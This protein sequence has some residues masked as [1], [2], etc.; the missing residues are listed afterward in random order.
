MRHS[1]DGFT[2]RFND[3]ELEEGPVPDMHEY[4]PQFKQ[5][6]EDLKY[7]FTIDV[8]SEE[9]LHSQEVKAK[10]YTRAVEDLHQGNSFSLEHFAEYELITPSDIKPEDLKQLH[11]DALAILQNL[12][13]TARLS[14]AKK[15][16]I[17]LGI[18]TEEETRV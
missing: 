7:M 3:Q 2:H 10:L 16:F 8:E 6:Q 14:T 12:R 18:L 1:P 4:E 13:S 11:I 9:E 5:I 17:E 15:L